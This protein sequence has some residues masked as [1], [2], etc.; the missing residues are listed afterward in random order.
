MRGTEGLTRVPDADLEQMLRLIHR[1]ILAC[2]LD[3]PGLTAAGL[4]RLGDEVEILRGLDERAVKA[5]LI[6]VLAERRR[7]R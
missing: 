2:P 4:F 3:M 6:A 5:V 7:R 1:G